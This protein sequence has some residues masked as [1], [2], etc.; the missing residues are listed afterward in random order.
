MTITEEDFAKIEQY[1]LTQIETALDSDQR[2]ADTGEMTLRL[3]TTLEAMQADAVRNSNTLQALADN[4]AAIRSTLDVVGERSEQLSVRM[5]TLETRMM[6]V[7]DAATSV[8]Q[9]VRDRFNV[10]AFLTILATVASIAA[11]YISLR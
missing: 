4:V 10:A 11:I 1:V 2:L 3:T 8:D 6:R 7:E 5:G 9:L